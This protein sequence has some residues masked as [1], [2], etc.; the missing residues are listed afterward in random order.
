MMKRVLC[1]GAA[2][3]AV[4]LCIHSPMAAAQS[5]PYN[6][7]GEEISSMNAWASFVVDLQ[8]GPMHIDMPELGNVTHGVEADVLGPATGLVTTESLS[9]GD[10]GWIILGF[11]S[12]ISDGPG[13]DFAVFENGISTEFGLFAEF[14]FV[15]VSSDDVYYARF[16]AIDLH[17][18][19]L[20][21]FEEVDP[22]Q[23]YN[24]AGDQPNGLGTGF[25]LAEL[26]S[27]PLVLSGDLDL[28]DVGYVRVIDVIGDGTTFESTG[29]KVY[30]PF[31][32]AFPTGGFDLNGIGVVNL[33]EPAAG[34][35][36]I[37]GCLGLLVLARRRRLHAEREGLVRSTSWI[38]SIICSIVAVGA[39][40][41]AAANDVTFEDLGLAPESF[42][43]GSDGAGGFVSGGV[44]FEN[45]YN[46]L[47]GTWDGFAASTTTDSVNGGFG[48]Q[49]SARTG[50][51]YGGSAT[52]GVGYEN[53]FDGRVPTLYLDDEVVMDSVQITNTT[54]AYDS[55]L[56]GDFAGKPFGGTSGDD[57]D[58]F[59]LTID[60]F[61][62]TGA[63]AGFVELYL[64]DYRF[65]DN[66]LDY[67]LKEWVE[68]DLTSLGGIASLEF[69]MT[70][71]DVGEFGI[72]TP[73]YFAMDDLA[74]AIPEPA[75]GLLVGI[76]FTSMSVARRRSRVRS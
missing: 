54:Y 16:D 22:S 3:A 24:V 56:N 50:A 67:I 69:S 60:G 6:E 9:L 65:A 73:T 39:A 27:H 20:L 37:A 28:D 44:T 48:N 47:W 42:T 1:R 36:L 75:S 35:M 21:P 4:H 74:Q 64:A 30:D 2:I 72:N 33:P 49:Y 70:S 32:T 61:D 76:G 23:Y 29:G 41:G 46:A 59:L 71:S 52:Y 13:V 40:S 18:L 34:L 15:E 10:G 62:S 26:A 7:P 31:P 38:H 25:D 53:T 45:T 8:R 5:G 58:W 57:E 66:S 55:I 43:N 12:G 51:G 11:D 68:V 17:G 63:H 14:G 19:P